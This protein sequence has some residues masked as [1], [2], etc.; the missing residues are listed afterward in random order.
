MA[1]GKELDIK[2]ND[3]VVQGI[4][5]DSR[6]IAPGNLFVPI[7]RVI[8]GHDYIIEAINKGAVA[9]LWQNDHPNPPDD[10]PL[11][12]VEDCLIALQQLA[13]S[14]RKQLPVKVVAITGSNGKT[15]TKDMVTSILETSYSVHK[16][17]GNLNSQI[18]L[19]LTLLEIEEHTQVAVLEMGMSERGQI[20]R[21]SQIAEPDI[22]VITMIGL[23]HLSSLG[24]KEEIAAAKLEI[25]KG[26]HSDGV[27]VLNGDEP[28]LKI[29][30][31]R[32]VH[33]G[34]DESN[35][36]YVSSIE[37]EDVKTLFTTN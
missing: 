25:V 4:S 23:S 1:S 30:F 16:T 9:A 10:I 18:G 26:L 15:T 8:D 31:N 6:T 5:I 20:E 34:T 21:L 29:D 3:I 35:D 19:P 14:Y 12:F 32:V 28:L 7:I 36:Y 17:K 11:I 33:F 13:Y 27:L 22:A 24:S 2:F 37:Q